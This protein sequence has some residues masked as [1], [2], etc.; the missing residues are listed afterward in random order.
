MKN[1]QIIFIAVLFL[2]P[3]GSYSITL[4]AIASGDWND[5][6]KWSETEGGTACSCQPLA[7]D[8]IYI[9]SGYTINI[10]ENVDLSSGSA[11]YVNIS[12]KL[13]FEQGNKLRLNCNSTIDIET[14]GSIEPEKAVG[15]N[16]LIEICSNEVWRA[17]DGTLTGPI[18]LDGN[19]L[20]INLVK[21]NAI[22]NNTEVEILWTTSNE[23]NNN[24]FTIERSIDGLCF[25][26]V[27]TKLGA[28]N[29]NT[30]LEYTLIDSEPIEGLS[31]YRL[32]QT[33]YNG[34][35]TYSKLIKVINENRIGFSFKVFPN[36]VS[37]NEELFVSIEGA[38]SEQEV[39]VVVYD[40]LGNLRY[41][42]VIFESVNNG[43]VM[44]IDPNKKLPV[45]TYIIVG[46]SNDKVYKQKLVIKK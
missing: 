4:Y 29:S 19:P 17:S 33:D 14:G 15:A 12:G 9:P 2:L 3:F 1:L 39:L 40:V 24:F 35:Y 23:L 11:T 10:T 18:T 21:F 6:S 7:G 34:D 25:E 44:A 46:T 30:I 31:Y 26:I 41:S 28:G 5:G 43:T 42:K 8:S 13:F 45:G 16:N 27:G 22:L 20:P 38:D 32:K 37:R 36:P